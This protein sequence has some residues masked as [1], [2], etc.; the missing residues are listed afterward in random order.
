[1]VLLLGTS[2]KNRVEDLFENI[3]KS[4]AAPCFLLIF[5]SSLGPHE[6]AKTVILL[7]TSLKNRFG[8]ICEYG[9]QK[10]CAQSPKMKNARPILGSFLEP[11]FIKIG[12]W[13]CSVL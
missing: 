11:N 6:D 10:S 12:L 1:M 5:E 4:D 13:S 2:F 8:G 9:S 7:Q 3:L